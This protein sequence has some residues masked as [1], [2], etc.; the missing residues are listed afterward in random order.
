MSIENFDFRTVHPRRKTVM[1]QVRQQYIPP[2]CERIPVQMERDE[3]DPEVSPRCTPY[4]VYVY[5]FNIENQIRDLLAEDIFNDVSNLVINPLNPFG[6]Y[7]PPDNRYD[8]IHSGDWYQR[9]YDERIVDSDHQILLGIK[10]YVVDKTGCDPMLQRHG[11][12]PVMFTFTIINNRIVTKP[13]GTLGLF[14][15]LTNGQSRNLHTIP[16]MMLAEGDPIEIIINAGIPYSSPFI[17][18]NQMV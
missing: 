13:G 5:R 14:L 15:I 7:T 10:I 2:E 12:E 18:F 17:K 3:G 4:T 11:L 1:G 6:K 16:Q 9:T 8:E